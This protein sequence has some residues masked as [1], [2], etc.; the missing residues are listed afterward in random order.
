MIKNK[1]ERKVYITNKLGLHAR[2]AAKFVKAAS[3][4]SS[5]IHVKKDKVSVNGSSILGLM[6][7]AATKGTQICVQ[8]E[9]KDAKK[10]LFTLTELIR[11]NFGEEKPVEKNLL[12]E[13]IHTGIGVSPG[14]YIGL[15]YLKEDVGYIFSR[16]KIKI[17]EVD[18]ELTRFNNAVKKSISELKYLIKKSDSKEYFGQN[19]MGFILQAHVM[20]LNSSSLVKQS[21]FKIKKDLINAEAAISDEL[22]NHEKTYKQIKNSYFKERFDD[23]R[24]VCRRVIKNLEKNKHRLKARESLNKRIIISEELSAA[25]LLALQKKKITGLV[26]ELG[27]PEGHFSIVARSFSIPTIVGLKDVLKNFNNDEKIVI[28]GDKGIVIQ[29][30]STRTIRKYEERIDHLKNEALKLDSFKKIQPITIDNKRVFIEANVDNAKEVKDAYS[31]GIDGIGLF[32]SEYLY[33]NKKNLPTEKE[34]FELIKNSIEELNGKVLTIRT[35]DIGNDKNIESFDKL[36]APSPNPAL[37]LRAIRLTLAFPKIFIKQITA[38]LKA[39][40]YGPLR[41]MLPM[42]S[43]VN[44]LNEAK[45]I[46]KKV[47]KDLQERGIKVPT[48]I[49]PIGVLIETPAA[50]LTADSLAESCDFLA[51]GTNDLTMYTLAIDRGDESVAKIYDPGH[52]SVLKLI[53]MS[54]DSGKSKKIPVSVCGEMAG[55]VFFTALLIGLGIRRLSMSTSRILKIKQFINSINYNETKI[56]AKK[57]LKETS[58]ERIRKILE[59]FNKNHNKKIQ[60]TKEKEEEYARL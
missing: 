3:G 16:Y 6:S 48:K 23:V 28:D 10:D 31:K 40:L 4:C 45:D 2:A 26:S 25:D 33:M 38:I 24:D 14:V 32:R 53:K 55:D 47:Y 5:K 15:C 49:P 36:I 58:S 19:E 44:E 56:L 60:Q 12:K 22:E 43:N 13:K 54:F 41:I 50:A 21:R 11:K 59:N 18:A 9:G 37:G 51:I 42:V 35:L 46:I 7:L 30:P 57:I 17:S 39:S 20:M 1:I 27:G 8:C 52:L 34:Q 29:N